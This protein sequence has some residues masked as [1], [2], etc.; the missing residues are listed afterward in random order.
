MIKISKE[1]EQKLKLEREAALKKPR[2]Y[3]DTKKNKTIMTSPLRFTPGEIS[4][5]YKGEGRG[6]IPDGLGEMHYQII[7]GND[8]KNTSYQGEFLGGVP[9]GKGKYKIKEKDGDVTYET[10]SLK[11]A[12]GTIIEGKFEGLN[13]KA[14]GFFKYSIKKNNKI[15]K[16]GNIFLFKDKDKT[17]SL[18]N[19]LSIETFVTGDAFGTTSK[20]AHT[21][22]Y[23]ENSI[24]TMLLD[25][26]KIIYRGEVSLMQ[27]KEMCLANRF[28]LLNGK[29]SKTMINLN[30]ESDWYNKKQTNS[31]TFNLFAEHGIIKQYID[32]EL[33]SEGN[34]T[35]GKRDGLFKFFSEDGTIQEKILFKNGVEQI[36]K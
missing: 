14:D 25:N 16:D 10:S 35:N 26:F 29:G 34:Y 7:L 22:K 31:G 21:L 30:K 36:N 5:S 33:I 17:S 8:I 11:K 2:T 24:F 15:F 12:D 23:N 27:N 13:L 1:L 18:Y 28:P 20:K 6:G 4:F 32:N 19:E 9:N 3:F